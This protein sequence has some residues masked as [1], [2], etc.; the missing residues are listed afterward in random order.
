MNFLEH[1]LVSAPPYFL[2]LPE[3]LDYPPAVRKAHTAAEKAWE[4]WKA[5]ENDLTAIQSDIIAKQ[6][7]FDHAI[8]DAAQT[9]NACPEPID[10]SGLENRAKYLVEVERVRRREVDLRVETLTNTV[11]EHRAD[12]ARAA[13]RTAEAGAQ[14]Y[15]AAVFAVAERMAEIENERRAAYSGLFLMQYFTAPEMTYT[16]D[17]G[18]GDDTRLPSTHESACSTTV[19]SLRRWLEVIESASSDLDQMEVG[20]HLNRKLVSSVNSKKAVA[21]S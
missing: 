4:G 2:V 9:G 14:D 21:N 6:A 18:T 16:F 8:T 17:P 7:T 3:N 19:A 20:A 10:L 1:A 12:I 13:I 11:H 15:R 5:A